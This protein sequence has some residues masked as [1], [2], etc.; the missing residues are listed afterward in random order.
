LETAWN[1]P[2]STTEGY[3][4]VGRQ[5]GMALARFQNETK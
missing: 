2:A 3:E 4:A 1:T 5:L